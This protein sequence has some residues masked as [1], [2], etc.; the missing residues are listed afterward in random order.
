MIGRSSVRVCSETIWF[1]HSNTPPSSS[2]TNASL[3][4][5][6][7]RQTT[8]EKKDQIVNSVISTLVHLYFTAKDD[9][10]IWSWLSWCTTPK[11]STNAK[12]EY[13]SSTMNYGK[14][15]RRIF[16]NG[17]G[18]HFVSLTTNLFPDKPSC[19]TKSNL[20]NCFNN[21]PL[22]LHRCGVLISEM[23]SAHKLMAKNNWV[24]KRTIP[25]T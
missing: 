14:F 13:L 4:I 1:K 6:Q 20:K 10:K 18:L 25:V 17:N 5:T 22:I 2:S 21:L 3:L 8:T 16:A 15:Q 12:V 19:N 11:S 7:F 23:L 24:P 9:S